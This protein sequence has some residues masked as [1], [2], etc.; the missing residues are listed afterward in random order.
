MGG[1]RVGT[2]SDRIEQL[3]PFGGVPGDERLQDEAGEHAQPGRKRR[4]PPPS[5][6]DAVATPRWWNSI[7]QPSVS[8]KCRRQSSTPGPVPIRW[9][10]QP[11]S[12]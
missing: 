7:E 10:C 5:Q 8:A 3:D 4:E 9:R 2:D 11:Q 12:E 6:A 1:D